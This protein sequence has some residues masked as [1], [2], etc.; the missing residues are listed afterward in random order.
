M[1]DLQPIKPDHFPHLLFPPV[2]SIISLQEVDVAMKVAS[3]L[4]V[5]ALLSVSTQAITPPTFPDG[6]TVTP[7]P[8][9]LT[10]EYGIPLHLA[11]ATDDTSPIGPFET[12]YSISSTSSD[13]STSTDERPRETDLTDWLKNIYFPSTTNT[14]SFTHWTPRATSQSVPS[15]SLVDTGV[16]TPIDRPVVITE[17]L[18]S[19]LHETTTSTTMIQRNYLSLRFVIHLLT[20]PILLC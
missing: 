15:S 16:P 9:V 3:T 4:T 19:V 18:S 12:I 20:Q 5:S 13:T 14:H 17:L 1:D 6:P 10:G 7:K 8:K 2:S 11:K